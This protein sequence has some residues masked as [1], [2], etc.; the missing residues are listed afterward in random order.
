MPEI[1]PGPGRRLFRP[2]DL[3]LQQLKDLFID[4]GCLQRSTG[5]RAT[6]GAI[7]L[8]SWGGMGT[9]SIGVWPKSNCRSKRCRIGVLLQVIA[10][11]DAAFYTT[12]TLF[13]GVCHTSRNRFTTV[14]MRN[15]ATGFGD[16]VFSQTL[17]NESIARSGYPAYPDSRS[18]P[19]PWNRF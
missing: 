6:R 5:A 8:D 1:H 17:C 7:H 2:L 9:A 14:N 4:L 15:P 10:V 16:R 3:L 18:C 12:I 19:C 11:N 13:S